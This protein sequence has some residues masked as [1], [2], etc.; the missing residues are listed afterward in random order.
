MKTLGTGWVRGMSWRD[1]EVSKHKS[2]RPDILISGGAKEVAD[3]LGID[4]IL[5]TISHCRAYATATAIAIQDELSDD[6]YDS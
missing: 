5:I 6:E 4:R 3:R 1:I 2:G